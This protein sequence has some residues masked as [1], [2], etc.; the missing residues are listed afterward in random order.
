MN[1]SAWKKSQVE[2]DTKRLSKDVCVC[3]CVSV[4]VVCVCVYVHVCLCVCV[5]V[6]VCVLCKVAGEGFFDKVSLEQRPEGNEGVSDVAI[7]T[8]ALKLEGK[9]MLN[10]WL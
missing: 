9:K 8:R 7:G 3:A 1:I 4:C 10:M 2:E 6:C 5:C